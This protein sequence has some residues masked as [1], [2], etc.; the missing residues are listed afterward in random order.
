MPIYVVGVRDQRVHIPSQAL[1]VSITGS[2]QGAE[3]DV[4]AGAD[5][6]VVRSTAHHAVL[7][8]MIG[9]VTVGVHPVGTARFPAGT[10][11]HLA[12]AHDDPGEVD[13]VQVLFGPV[14][15]SGDS[16]VVFAVLRPRGSQIEVG[17]SAVADTPLS[18]LGSAARSSAR[19]V[20]GRGPVQSEGS[21]VVALDTSGSMRPW[22][23]DGS[24]AA[25][26]DIVV[27]VAAAVGFREVSAVLV[28]AEVT[29]VAL[30]SAAAPDAGGIELADAVRHAQ[31]RWSAGVRWARLALGPRTIVCTDLS[32]AAVRQR[33]PVITLSNDRRFDAAGARLPSPRPGED[34][35][36][37]LLAH[38]PVLDGITAALVRALT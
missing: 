7:P 25:A 5:Q 10:V 2:V 27:G 8:R 28:G 29:P 1:A 19:K 22:F 32:T 31:P 20:I 3:L 34:A 37:E 17:V 4:R 13:P 11:I 21:V 14:D 26:T 33:F 35:T 18:P 24:V 30:D 38:P 6:P 15:V 12:I 9:P 36:A 16:G 23:A